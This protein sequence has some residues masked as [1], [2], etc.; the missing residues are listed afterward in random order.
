MY[1]SIPNMGNHLS[2][3]VNA[4]PSVRISNLSTYENMFLPNGEKVSIKK[5]K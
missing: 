4:N 3:E 2:E 5:K 1:D